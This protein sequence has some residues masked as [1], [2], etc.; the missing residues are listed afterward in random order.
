M[1]PNTV[2][3]NQNLLRQ[4]FRAFMDTAKLVMRQIDSE[5]VESQDCRLVNVAA[6]QRAVCAHY[7]I[8]VSSMTT[9]IR[10]ANY[11]LARQ[12]AM[13]QAVELTQHTHIDIG[14]CFKRNHGTVSFASKA[15]TNR[16]TTSKS[17]AAEYQAIH[18]RCKNAIHDLTMP[19]FSAS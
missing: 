18:L 11:A 14:E 1:T 10:T 6:I 12:V 19:L 13:V 17:F 7:G 2:K 9:R 5:A 15:I 3:E 8:P 16:I 4:Q